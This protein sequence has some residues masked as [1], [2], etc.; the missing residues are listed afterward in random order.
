[1][2]SKQ[3]AGIRVSEEYVEGNPQ[4]DPSATELVINVLVAGQ[5]M[6]NRLDEVLRPHGLSS[7]TFTLLQIVA[8]DLD[9][10]TPSQIASRT[11]VP[12]T[13]ATVTGLLDTCERKGWV[14]RE[15]HPTD[16]RMVI[17][18]ITDEG[19]SVLAAAG[20]EVIAGERRWAASTPPAARERLIDALGALADHLR[21]PAAAPD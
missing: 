2:A 15:R 8:G 1:M 5:L 20:Q 21:S 11:P 14:V 18:R 19:R 10:V 3:R 12:V 16:R 17:V 4:A 6:A 9:P 7:S 13:T